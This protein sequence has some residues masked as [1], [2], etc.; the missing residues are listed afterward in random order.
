MGGPVTPPN[1]AS[2]EVCATGVSVL[3]AQARAL[4]FL[5]DLYER[6]SETQQQFFCVSQIIHNAV[7]T[8]GKVVIS[9]V[10]KSLKIAEKIVATLNSLGVHAVTLHPTEALHGDLGILRTRDVLILITSSGST[11]ELLTLLDYVPQGI[12]LTCLTGSPQSEIARRCH[13]ILVATVPQGMSEV[14]VYGLAAPT[15]S[16]TACLAVGDAL[17]I[18]V[19]EMLECDAKKRSTNFGRF[20]PGGAIGQM[21]A[22]SAR[23]S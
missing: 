10:G 2:S 6:D 15:V 19:A 5:A 17:C 14:E 7:L 3:R 1:E 8:N 23:Q 22:R 11:P 12:H 21:Y 18:T 9:G 20:H 16:T 4:A 13:G